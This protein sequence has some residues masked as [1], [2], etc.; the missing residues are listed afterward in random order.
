[1][2]SVMTKENEP[3]S[4]WE[5]LRSWRMLVNLF[6]GL[7]SGLPL[8][9]IGSTLQAWMTDE[10]VSLS[11][12]GLVSLVGIP[13]TFKFAWAPLIDRYAPPFLGRRRSWI[14][15]AQMCLAGSVAILSFLSPS[16]NPWP[17][18]AFAILI[19]F[20]SAT[21]DIAVD[22]YRREV[23]RDEE[24]GLGS[25]M[26]VNG[27]RIGM[28]ISGSLALVFADRMPWHRVYLLMAAMFVVL[29]TITVAAPDPIEKIQPPH[30]LKDAVVQPFVEYFRRK[31]AIE[32]LLFI[33][34]YQIGNSMAANLTTRF[35]MELAF[36]KR[37]SGLLQRHSGWPQHCSVRSL[38]VRLF[39]A[40]G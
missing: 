1:M 18:A 3:I 19:A 22:A 25:S 14:F 12:V 5:S 15:M 40:G 30:S 10:K 13:Y 35:Y 20:F 21:Q 33:L 4:L 8:L 27:Y 36:Q 26:Y 2:E 6:F 34:L 11:T 24:L 23:L 38:A 32:V 39:C 16:K 17:V 37:I 31:S 7:S 29:S 28:L 9:M